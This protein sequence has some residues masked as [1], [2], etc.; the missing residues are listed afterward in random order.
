MNDMI[1]TNKWV[2]RA[3]KDMVVARSLFYDFHPKQLE[4]CC[5]QC[6][7]AVEKI[8]KAY[9]I[10]K[11]VAFPFIHD[12]K[13]LCLLCADFDDRFDAYIDDC[14]DLTPYATQSR[15]PDNDDVEESETELAVEKAERILTF[16][17]SLIVPENGGE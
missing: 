12:L 5:Y 10:F 7:Q 15:Y 3:K 9:L 11:N 2:E 17:V 4:I 6:Q 1:L 8:L 13:K 16:C 14:A